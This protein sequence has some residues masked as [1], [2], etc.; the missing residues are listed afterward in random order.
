MSG[1]HGGKPWSGA[2]E[3][4]GPA[5]F[6]RRPN[7]VSILNHRPRAGVSMGVAMIVINVRIGSAALC[8]LSGVG[9]R[10]GEIHAPAFARPISAFALL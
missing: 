2:Y 10:R 4:A 8:V 7:E 6:G 1:F 9:L 5:Q 3:N